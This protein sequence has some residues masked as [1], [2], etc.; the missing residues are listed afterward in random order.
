MAPEGPRDCCWSSF[1]ATTPAQGCSASPV[2]LTIFRSGL[3]GTRMP[4]L[5]DQSDPRDVDGAPRDVG[6]CG[7]ASRG[8]PV[9]PDGSG[10][11]VLRG[12]VVVVMVIRLSQGSVA[13]GRPIWRKRKRRAC[14]LVDDLCLGGWV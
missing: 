3:S 10:L 7:A 11:L 1:R 13:V 5:R 14:E 12:R 2:R 4:W 6:A 9:I 8:C